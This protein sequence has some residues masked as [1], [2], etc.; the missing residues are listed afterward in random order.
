MK[1]SDRIEKQIVLEAPRT[2]V[3][4]A[5]TDWKEFSTWFGVK[6]EG[7]F[8][9]GRA[10]RGRVTAKGYEHVMLDLTVERMEP[11]KLFS[12]RWV[13]HAVDPNVDYSKEPTTLVEFRLEDAAGGT[14]LTVVESGFDRVPPHRRDEAFRMNSGGWAQQVENLRR[15]VAG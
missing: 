1:T 6:L 3:W 8:Q 12:Y 13:P 2:R 9:I 4:R 15:H 11:E 10:A 5:L 14:R 7:P